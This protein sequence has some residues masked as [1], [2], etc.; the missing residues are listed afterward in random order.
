MKRWKDAEGAYFDVL[1]R[2]VAPLGA[3]AGGALGE[4]I[5]LRPTLVVGAIGEVAGFLWVWY[6]PLRAPREG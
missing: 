2:G 3:L 4:A 1:S 5:G 6:S